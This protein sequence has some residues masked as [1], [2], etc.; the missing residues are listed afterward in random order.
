MMVAMAH[1]RALNKAG[2]MSSDLPTLSLGVA[3]VGASRHS[4]VAPVMRRL[5]RVIMD[6][7]ECLRVLHGSSEC[8][9]P[10]TLL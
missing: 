2:I 3:L 4:H 9:H 6:T 10:V 8:Q 7:L 5:V 1:E